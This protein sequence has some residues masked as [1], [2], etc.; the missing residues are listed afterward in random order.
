MEQKEFYSLEEVA[1]SLDRKRAT[2]YSR[3]KLIGMRGHKFKGDRK[4]YLSHEELERL[5]N[6]FEKP[7]TAGEK[8][9]KS[10]GKSEPTA[11]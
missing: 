11:A 6:A 8:T 10:E 4:T 5:K 7:W 9:E 1:K 3:M 2:V